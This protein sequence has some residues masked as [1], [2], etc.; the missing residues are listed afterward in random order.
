MFIKKI[1]QKDFLDIWL[2]RNDN[3]TIFFSKKKNKIKLKDHYKWLNINL[4]SKKNFFFIGL[5]NHNY[6]KEKVGI[7]RFYL[8]YK[9][10]LVSINLNPKMRGRKLSYILLSKSIK[11]FLKFKK[12]KMVAEI[13]KK[14]YASISIF[15][16][17]KFI[18]K[19]ARKNYNLYCRFL[20]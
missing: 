2:W 6:K 16:K 11:K 12:V 7:V 4:K 17:N 9:H 3:K 5:I 18:L 8:K 20:D 15:L 19:Q 10:A 13:D 14:N 1:S